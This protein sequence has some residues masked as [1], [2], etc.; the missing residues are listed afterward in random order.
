MGCGSWSGANGHLDSLPSSWP[1]RRPYICPN[2]SH[3]DPLGSC[4]SSS[5]TAFPCYCP[6]LCARRTEAPILPR[7]DLCSQRF[8][9]CS[10]VFT[11]FWLPSG[12]WGKI[13]RC[14]LL[15]TIDFSPT[16][17]C[18]L[19]SSWPREVVWLQE[20]VKG[21]ITASPVQVGFDFILYA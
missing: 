14:P 1:A 17:C 12:G 16:S 11:S 21:T 13:H 3:G 20:K 8:A 5:R 7:L 6:N 4:P 19:N 9:G 18:V 10:S 15:Q 2:L